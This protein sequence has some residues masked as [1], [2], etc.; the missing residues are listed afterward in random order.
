[1]RNV[2]LAHTRSAASRS[3][4]RRSRPC[5][6]VAS[7]AS[8]WY[9]ARSA[10][11]AARVKSASKVGAPGFAPPPPAPRGVRGANGT[12]AIAQRVCAAG[13]CASA[14]TLGAR[15]SRASAATL[16]NVALTSGREARTA[17]ESTKGSA[18]PSTATVPFSPQP[19]RS[20]DE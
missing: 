14:N 12:G 1:M 5:A 11:C 19:S 16:A 2:A 15:A 18:S 7:R 17:C 10:S 8:A 20:S 4:A 9:R 6:S 13:G 3:G